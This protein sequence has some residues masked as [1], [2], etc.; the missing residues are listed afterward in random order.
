MKWPVL[1]LTCFILLLISDLLMKLNYIS[2]ITQILIIINIKNLMFIIKWRSLAMI[3]SWKRKS[4]YKQVWQNDDQALKIQYTSIKDSSWWF[5]VIW[6]FSIQLFVSSL[7]CLK[8]FCEF[9][10]LRL[11]LNMNDRECKWLNM[12]LPGLV[13]KF[14]RR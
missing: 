7:F 12:K 2:E 4:F 5:Y 1:L 6:Q 14:C 3:A 10:A 13:C 11:L 8:K 9:I